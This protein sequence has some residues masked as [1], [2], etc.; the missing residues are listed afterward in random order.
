MAASD[1]HEIVILGAN[2][3][4]ISTAH[5]LLRHTIPALSQLDSSISYRV[6]L[7]SPSTHFFWKVGA[8]RTLVGPDLLP[9]DKAF[10][11]IADG[12]KEYSPEQYRFIQGSAVG[13]DADQKVV[14]IQQ[15]Q[16]TITISYSTLVIATGTSSN[17]A[18]WTLN[19]SHDLSVQAFK[20]MHEIL[21]TAKTI[22]I[23]GGGESEVSNITRTHITLVQDLQERKP[24]AK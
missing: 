3:A 17:T 7:V 9:I 22:L 14:T 18:L 2:F 11:P 24:P 8:P 5:Y 10:I 20:E 19:G 6:S 23:A 12:F 4:G 15:D 21:P 13:L 1:T 16:T